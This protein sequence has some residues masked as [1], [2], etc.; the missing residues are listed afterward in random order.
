MRISSS[1]REKNYFIL[2]LFTRTAETIF[3]KEKRRGRSDEEKPPT[4][5]ASKE[6]GFFT[7]LWLNDNCP[8]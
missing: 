7:V 2:K 8:P 6:I 4:L 5:F 3:Q 1:G